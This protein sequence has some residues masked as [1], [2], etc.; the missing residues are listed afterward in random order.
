MKFWFQFCVYSLFRMRYREI[1]SFVFFCDGR[2]EKMCYVNFS[3]SEKNKISFVYGNSSCTYWVRGRNIYAYV[4]VIYCTKLTNCVRGGAGR[5]VESVYWHGHTTEGWCDCSVTG[6][7]GFLCR[8]L[9]Q[10]N[11]ATLF[12][13]SLPICWHD[14]LSL[15]SGAHLDPSMFV[16]A[17]NCLNNGT[18]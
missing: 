5:Q 14:S 2:I 17:Y 6:I 1:V 10:V 15:W 12:H 11:I 16:Y 13:S 9:S 3:T 18:S 8:M 7:M 4:K